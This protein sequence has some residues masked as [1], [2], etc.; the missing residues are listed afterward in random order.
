MFGKYTDRLLYSNSDKFT[1]S[2]K[3]YLL[4]SNDRSGGLY[5][6]ESEINSFGKENIRKLLCYNPFSTTLKNDCE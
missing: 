1:E 2:Q 3:E 5:N 4:H 6:P